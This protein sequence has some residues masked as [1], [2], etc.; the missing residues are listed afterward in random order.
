MPYP[1]IKIVLGVL[2]FAPWVTRVTADVERVPRQVAP[3]ERVAKTVVSNQLRLVFA[4]G[5]EG[6]GHH[7]TFAVE[8]LMF[9]N[10]PDLPRLQDFQLNIGL[11]YT[12]SVMDESP[13]HFSSAQTSARAEMREL[14]RRAEGVPWPGTIQVQRGGLSYP[15][16]HGPLKV[17]GYVDVR[18]MAE[19][20]EAEGV[21]FRVLYL[22][23]SAKDLIIA[24]TIH[25]DFQ[26]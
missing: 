11:Y 24:N 18:M 3:N 17:F 20:A 12:A 1:A 22:R 2:G 4:M 23:R 8:D 5:L 26:K 7:Y 10:N 6:T 9:H 13:L 21:D 25:R 19:A 16:G 14:A 15:N